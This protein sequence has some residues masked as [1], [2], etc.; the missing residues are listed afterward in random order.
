MKTVGTHGSPSPPRLLGC[1]LLLFV[2]GR[3]LVPM[4]ETD[5]FFNL[6]LGE[7][8][9]ATHD[10]PRTNLM[11]FTYPDTRDVNL[12][13][14][15]QIV[16]GLV[17]RAAGIPGTVL[18]KTLLVVATFAVLFRVA[19][20]R[21]AHPAAAAAALALAAW[22]AEPRFVERPH[23]VTLLGLALTLLA[24]ERAEG[25]RPRALWALVPAG[26]V[27][28]NANSCFFLAPVALLLYAAGARLDGP[29]AYGRRAALVAAALAPLVLATPSGV[30]ALSYIANHFRMPTLRPL[31][32]YRAATWPLDGPFF[33]L[34]TALLLGALGPA[35]RRWRH[36]LPAV[37]LGLLGARRI[38]FV[39]EFALL[40]GPIV[41]V[42]ITRFTQALAARS[43]V[44]TRASSATALAVGALLVTLTVAPR[45]VAVRRGERLLDLGVETDL[46][47]T[48]AIRF[49][50]DLQL[51]DRMYN[52]LEVGSYLTWEGWP[53]HRVFQDPRINGYPEA[54]HALL[55]RTDL[56]RAEWQAFLDGFGVTSALISYPDVN[57][58]AALFDPAE[59]ALMYRAREA[60]VFARR[61]AQWL[62]IIAQHELPVTFARDGDGAIAARPLEG[63]PPLS[64]VA[65]CVWQWRL[66]DVLVETGADQRARPL[67]QRALREREVGCAGPEQRRLLAVALGDLALRA[68]DPAA[69]ALAYADVPD[70]GVR[71]KRGLALLTRHRPTEALADFTAARLAL[72]DDPEARLGE[73]LALVALGRRAEASSALQDFLRRA[74]HHVAAV[75]ARAALEK[76]AAP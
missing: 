55:R 39:A 6:R 20:R 38:R 58:R 18:L 40:A 27:W 63:K 12:A 33:F 11:S 10:V 44:V 19:R 16:L 71:V 22:A 13:W 73:G 34:A 46:F 68:G 9:L 32:E 41:A 45:V 76:L 36:L 23:L 25:G 8:V 61:R 29:R 59:W 24:L 72:P 1:A 21:G 28:A 42:T 67:Y 49:A 30:G 17:H 47:P 66:A 57:P 43:S 26:L 2:A 65:D 74:P 64:P 48:V 51:R 50:E 14:L 56:S 70:A 4:D 35:T 7:I 52:D 31:Q 69:A 15:F 54:M 53:R 5:L 3:C 75:R 60:L 37:A 62:P